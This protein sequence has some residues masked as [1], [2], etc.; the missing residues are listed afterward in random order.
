M[1]SDWPEQLDTLLSGRSAGYGA[2]PYPTETDVTVTSLVTWARTASFSELADLSR[3]LTDAHSF[4]LLCYAE[5]MA[6]LAVRSGTREPLENGL[7]AVALEAARVD[8]REDILILSLLYRSAS[9]VGINAEELFRGAA[10][11]AVGELATIIRD[12]PSRPEASRS[13]EA[14]G[15]RESTSPEGFTYQRTW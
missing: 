4:T 11:S 12:F 6:N 3:R 9:K 8:W 7:L 2:R 5:R 14:M 13:I 10:G 15:Y 1:A